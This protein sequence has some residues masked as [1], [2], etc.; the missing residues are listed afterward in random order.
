MSTDQYGYRS[1]FNKAS[2]SFGWHEPLNMK[3][4]FSGDKQAVQKEDRAKTF[5][6]KV[7]PGK[8]FHVDQTAGAGLKRDPNA[9]VHDLDEAEGAN[10]ANKEDLEAT[11]A[12]FEDTYKAA[13]GE[14]FDTVAEVAAE[15]EIKPGDVMNALNPADGEDMLITNSIPLGGSGS[16][17]TMGLQVGTA[18]DEIAQDR[19]KLSED[20]LKSVLEEAQRRLSS[21]AE[22]R[23]E[24]FKT[25][26][27]QGEKASSQQNYEWGALSPDEF[28]GFLQSDASQQPEMLA[29]NNALSLAQ[30]NEENHQ[31]VENKEFVL[32]SDKLDDAIERGDE[33]K[34]VDMAGGKDKAA[35]LV[36]EV[37][38]RA[39]TEFFAA[40]AEEDPLSAAEVEFHSEALNDVKGLKPNPMQFKMDEDVK[41]AMASLHNE[42]DQRQLLENN[43]TMTMGTTGMM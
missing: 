31:D 36:E 34:I 4:N 38:D 25:D 35:D 30:E 28:K 43:Q 29:I 42:P 11:K 32:T 16:L 7:A 9:A 22:N 23:Q 1:A 17:M 12:D 19:Q 37:T 20:Q 15:Q 40:E 26:S 3:A 21:E 5:M 13:Q 6:Q 24:L 41:D 18:M 33:Q 10:Q 2:N 27:S 14:A 39:P 8:T